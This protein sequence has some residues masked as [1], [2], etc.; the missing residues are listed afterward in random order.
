MQIRTVI[1]SDRYVQYTSDKNDGKNVHCLKYNSD[2]L[3][4]FGC[5]FWIVCTYILGDV[6]KTLLFGF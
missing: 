3:S 4:L 6:L 5:L 2:L 1:L